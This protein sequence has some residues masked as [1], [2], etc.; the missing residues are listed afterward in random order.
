MT[1]DGRSTQ[2]QVNLV[3]A[4][5]EFLEISDTVQDCL[6][7]R[8]R[9]IEIMLLSLLIDTNAFECEIAAWSEVRLDWTGEEEGI[10][11]FEEGYTVGD[12]VEFIRDYPRHLNCSAERWN[13]FWRE[14]GVQISPSPWEKWRSPTENLAPST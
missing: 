7:I 4:I 2:K 1:L 5:P 12:E 8:N 3:I 9:H 6:T 14:G 13:Q 10:I 11:Q